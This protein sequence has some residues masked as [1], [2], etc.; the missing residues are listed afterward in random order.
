L[1]A[2]KPCNKHADG[3]VRAVLSSLHSVRQPAM[4]LLA[5]TRALT[6]KPNP[7]LSRRTAVC[8]FMFSQVVHV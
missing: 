8:Y 6:G 2:K 5:G 4:V 3:V 7:V 1:S